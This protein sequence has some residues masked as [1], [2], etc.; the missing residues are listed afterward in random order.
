MNDVNMVDA[1]H[2]EAV[3]VL[4]NLK[5]RCSL[6]VSREVL[7]VMPDEPLEQDGEWQPGSLN[8]CLFS[9][10]CGVRFITSS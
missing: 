7:V 8:V 2:T 4:K 3:K 9:E 6:V 10:S 5:E 1:T